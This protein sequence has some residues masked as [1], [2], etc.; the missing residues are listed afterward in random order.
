MILLLSSC[1]R[2]GFKTV[3]S[4][5]NQYNAAINNTE[6]EQLLLNIVRFR[7]T[8]NPYFL[9]VSSIS[10]TV[11]SNLTLGGSQEKGFLGGF[12]YSERPTLIYSPLGGKDFVRQLLNRI[13]LNKLYL[14]AGAGW[15]LDDILRL[16]VN[17]INGIRNAPSAVGPTPEITPKFQK[18]QQIADIFDRLDDNSA[19]LIAPATGD[20]EVNELILTLSPDEQ[21]SPAAIE[22]FELLGLAPNASSYRMKIGLGKKQIN[23][24]E[25]IIET[26]PLMGT[27]F[28]ISHGVQVPQE[29]LD[30]GQVHINRSS[31]NENYNWHPMLTGLF[32]V[33]SSSSKPDNP[34]LAVPYKG[35]WFYIDNTDIDSKETMVLMSIMFQLQA[36]GGE[37]I[38]PV[39]TLPVGGL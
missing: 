20:S 8:D 29:M 23:S 15:E 14:L 39:L 24:D 30:S 26:R 36:G 28:F 6:M 3:Q 37:S 35:Y 13:D 21:N 5:R 25:I 1:A 9:Q 17:N 16:F 31:G 2:L 27:M 22:L 18:F 10:S 19:I 38:S 4:G 12:E 7:F 33:R 32:R 11:E 34:Y